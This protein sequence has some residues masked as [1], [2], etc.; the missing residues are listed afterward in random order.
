MYL[1]RIDGNI[2]L[3]VKSVWVISNCLT[4]STIKKGSHVVSDTFGSF[5]V[6]ANDQTSRKLYK[7]GSKYK[8]K[9]KLEIKKFLY[10]MCKMLQ[11]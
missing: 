6:V 9:Y 3:K 8:L 4:T 7:K 5:V 11:M 2:E 10:L 1:G